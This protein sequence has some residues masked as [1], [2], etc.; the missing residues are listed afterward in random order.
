MSFIHDLYLVGRNGF[1]LSLFGKLFVGLFTLSIVIGFFNLFLINT[2]LDY[3]LRDFAGRTAVDATSLA[4]EVFDQKI[5]ERIAYWR[6]YF[7]DPSTLQKIEQLDQEFEKLPN[8]TELIAQRNQQW[9][10][11]QLDLKQDKWFEKIANHPES[12]RLR[13]FTDN[14]RFQDAEHFGIAEIFFANEYGVTT[15]MGHQTS[16]YYQA[17]EEWWQAAM[18]N[19]LFIGDVEYDQSSGE[20]GITISFRV[21]NDHKVLGVAKVVYK[22]NDAK[23]LFEEILTTQLNPTRPVTGLVGGKLLNRDHNLIFSIGPAEID[24]SYRKVISNF[25]YTENLYYCCVNTKVNNENKKLLLAVSHPHVT[26]KHISI[27]WV[28]V[29]EYDL[30][31]L[32]SP[33]RDITLFV[34][35]S[36]VIVSIVVVIFCYLYFNPIA[37]TI[38][39]LEE[40]MS[41]VVAGDL[42]INT[43]VKRN[44]ELGELASHFDQMVTKLA[45]TEKQK[46]DFIST[47]THGLK[48]PLTTIKWNLEVL[49]N[50]SHK[51]PSNIKTILKDIY[52]TSTQMT[53]TISDVLRVNKIDRLSDRTRGQVLDIGELIM[54]LEDCLSVMAKTSKKTLK[55]DTG[56]VK[57]KIFIDKDAF[58]DILQNLVSN[59]LK[60]SSPNGTVYLRLRV[61]N[62]QALIEVEDHGIGIPAK[63]QKNIFKEFFRASNVTTAQIEGTGLGLFICSTEAKAWNGSISFVSKEGEGSTF[64]LSL[65][66]IESNKNIKGNHSQKV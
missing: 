24:E 49:L 40:G 39:E 25:S 20:Y 44:D 61:V 65:P 32:L 51:L 55:F 50:D 9:N 4:L 41:K 66:I 23:K 8:K 29:S 16:D 52:N 34:L 6:A 17:D 26:D 45:T 57:A 31:V 42:S 14:S 58:K 43:K 22:L 5:N 18:K 21:E 30:N 7:H 46:Q 48:S 28:L 36:M 63:E 1:R 10:S 62:K 38:I 2:T 53:A 11:G 59:G 33:L 56:N 54:S 60:Y 3:N 13:T 35:L 27:N 19:K 12:L 47:A 37:N 64:T 15:I